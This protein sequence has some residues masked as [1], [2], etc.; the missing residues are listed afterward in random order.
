MKIRIYGDDAQAKKFKAVLA[1]KPIEFEKVIQDA[2]QTQYDK[3]FFET[4]QRFLRSEIDDA[5]YEKLLLEKPS[6]E[7]KLKQL[8]IK[9]SAQ[10]L[11]Q[12]VRASILSDGELDDNSAEK[13]IAEI[14]FGAP[15]LKQYDAYCT[16]TYWTHEELKVMLDVI[17]ERKKMHISELSFVGDNLKLFRMIDTLKV[18]GKLYE[19]K[20]YILTPL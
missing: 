20:Q 19:P 10:K 15:L 17:R 12:N 11:I 18:E 9:N 4:R 6:A 13:P 1:Q 5:T 7:L 16:D 8:G 14:V 2:V 3:L